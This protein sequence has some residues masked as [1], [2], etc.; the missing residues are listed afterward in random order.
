MAADFVDRARIR[1]GELVFDLGA[2]DGVLCGELL[3]RRAR[4]IAV[5]RDPA[6]CRRLRGRFGTGLSVVDGDIRAVRLP[7]SRF[8]VVSNLPFAAGRDIVHRLLASHSL[9]A[10]D[11][12][13]ADGFAREVTALTSGWLL[14]AAVTFDVRRG[15]ALPASCFRP[16]PSASARVLTIRRRD[17]PLVTGR[18]LP[19]Y[20][21]IAEV[22]PRLGDDVVWPEV[23]RE[24]L[25][26]KEIHRLARDRRLTLQVP[27]LSLRPADWAAV[28][29]RSGVHR[30]SRRR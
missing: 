25:S 5:E 22:V 4:L 7:H 12:I 6:L 17:R 8:R 29:A 11:L 23:A 20:D 13:V 9:D 3:S 30:R 26:T 24:L 14:P 18:A 16:A 10:A 28:S 27:A 21:W 2:G 19:A 15:R 1:P